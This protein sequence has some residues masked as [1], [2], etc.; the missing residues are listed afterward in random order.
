MR[1]IFIPA[2]AFLALS[3]AVA[4]ADTFQLSGAGSLTGVMSDLIRRFPA[5]TDTIA[6]PEFGPSG[7]MRQ[8]IEAGAP[9]DL[10]T[11]ADMAH[12]RALVAGRAERMVIHFTRNQLCALARPAIGL[13]PANMLDRLLDP[14][15]RIATS[16]P[17]ADPGGDYAWAVFARAEALHPGARAALEAKAQPLVGGGA[18]TPLLVPGK[19]AVEGVFLA[20]RADVMLGYCSSGEPVRREIPALVNVPLPAGLAVGPAY[21]MVL[22]NA[23]PVT[24]RFAAFVMSETGQSVLRA[25]GFD[26]VALAE[27]PAPVPGVFVQRRGLTARLL[28]PDRLAALPPFTQKITPSHGDKASELTGPLLWDVLAAA[29]AI[30]P[31]KPAEQVRLTVRVTGADGYTAVIALAELS[32]EFAGHPVLLATTL[33]GTAL[34]PGSLRLVVPGEKRGGRSVRD[35]VR[36]DV[37]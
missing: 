20:D 22:L 14:A 35:V 25:Y 32:P 15:V 29:G 17:G 3:T 11:S 16:T 7:L 5:G 12:A 10:F 36:I 13:T 37:D 19:G 1:R 24:L 26:P 34:P 9:A 8:K 28:A 2:F 30:D 27:Q 18:K 33:N 6:P 4:S 23:K 21:G 31:A